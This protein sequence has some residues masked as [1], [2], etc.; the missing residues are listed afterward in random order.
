MFFYKLSPLIHQSSLEI[1]F[2]YMYQI[3]GEHRHHKFRQFLHLVIPFLF[4]FS[5]L[6]GSSIFSSL[7]HSS[8]LSPGAAAADSDLSVRLIIPWLVFKE[9]SKPISLC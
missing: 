9:K 5:R 4:S 3:S 2:N 8:L 6:S 7:P 1:D